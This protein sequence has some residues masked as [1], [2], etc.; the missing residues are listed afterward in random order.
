M[1]TDY[2]YNE[3]ISESEK[4]EHPTVKTTKESLCLEASEPDLTDIILEK[5]KKVK[6]SRKALL[7]STVL[8]IDKT[9]LSKYEMSAEVI[10]PIN[11]ASE[12]SDKDELAPEEVALPDSTD[13][14]TEESD[15]TR[16][17]VIA[18]TVQPAITEINIK[19]TQQIRDPAKL[20]YPNFKTVE[21]SDEIVAE[22]V[23]RPKLTVARKK[24]QKKKEAVP[25]LHSKVSVVHLQNPKHVKG[26]VE[27]DS[28]EVDASTDL[29]ETLETEQRVSDSP[30]E[31]M[32]NSYSSPT[33]VAQA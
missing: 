15:E 26:E 28:L 8:D 1:P 13:V 4:F 5:P 30:I 33:I 22:K 18:E 29:Q 31:G 17:D 20:F 2:D 16:N 19:E 23:S 7:E 11:K 24:N 10:G 25:E 32:F 14:D 12:D 9:E 27:T 21:V 6:S 3:V